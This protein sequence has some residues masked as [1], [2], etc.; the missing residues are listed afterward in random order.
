[1]GFR[2]AW[3]VGLVGHC[4]HPKRVL[5]GV[6]NG[7]G[8]SSWNIDSDSLEFHVLYGLGLR[9]DGAQQA[10][11]RKQGEPLSTVLVDMVSSGRACHCFYQVDLTGNG[12][13]K[14]LEQLPTLI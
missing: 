7:V 9:T 11:S 4:Q 10:L 2:V 13:W 12:S 3:V 5:S 8:P 1:V 14:E 6:E